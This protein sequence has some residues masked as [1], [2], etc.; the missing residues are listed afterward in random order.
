[1]SASGQE[2]RDRAQAT[3]PTWRSRVLCATCE[4]ASAARASLLDPRS[5]CRAIASP[6]CVGLC[7]PAAA[8]AA[9]PASSSWSPLQAE[10]MACR[11]AASRAPLTLALGRRACS[12]RRREQQDAP[13]AAAVPP[14]PPQPPPVK[15]HPHDPRVVSLLSSSSMLVHEGFIS[16]SEESSLM[17]ELSPV[18]S[19]LRIE[20]DHWD[21]AITGFRETERSSWRDPTNALLIQRIKE[22][23]FPIESKLVPL[24]HVHVLDLTQDG[25][26]RPH[27]DAVRFCGPVIAGLSLLSDCVFRLALASPDGT[28]NHEE[29]QMACDF[30][31]PRRSLYVMRDAARFDF[32]HSV[33]PPGESVIAGH[34]VPRGRRVSILF[35][36]HPVPEA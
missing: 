15:V 5:S 28:A 22:F 25:W 8:A 12:Q 19:K 6:S 9:A 13:A 34:P 24:P 32:C 14:P 1:M 11:L 31:L 17:A 2:A 23:V 10:A 7:A 4:R 16:E 36:C 35:R 30:W 3:G 27:V 29:G 20:S 26:I 33:L 18:L 21:A